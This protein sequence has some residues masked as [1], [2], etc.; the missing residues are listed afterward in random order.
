MLYKVTW[1]LDS[2][3]GYTDE[4]IFTNSDKALDFMVDYYKKGFIGLKLEIVEGD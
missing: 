3:H 1:L 4:E 2:E